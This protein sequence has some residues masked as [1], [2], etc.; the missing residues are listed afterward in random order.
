MSL[1]LLGGVLLHLEDCFI[2]I[3]IGVIAQLTGITTLATY[4]NKK[5]PQL[6]PKVPEPR[7]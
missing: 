7:T 6:H 5:Q 2:T 4:R 3:L 1:G